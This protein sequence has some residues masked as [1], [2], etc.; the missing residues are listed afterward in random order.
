[1]PN[2]K[3]EAFE[4]GDAEFPIKIAFSIERSD[5]S[6]VLCT[7]NIELWNISPTHEKALM[8][9]GTKVYLCAGYDDNIPQIFEGTVVCCYSERDG[10]NRKT[11]IQCIDKSTTLSD[12]RI[13]ISQGETTA[14]ALIEYVR[15]NTYSTFSISDKAKL[16]LT[17]TKVSGYSFIGTA[18]DALKDICDLGGVQYRISN[19]IALIYLSGES[20][21]NKVHAIDAETG[22]IGFPKRIFESSLG[23]NDNDE[24]TGEYSLVGWEIEYLMNPSIGVGDKI[25]LTSKSAEL[26]GTFYVYQLQISGDNY[27]SDWTCTARIRE[28]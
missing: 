12:K 13:S 28:V 1:M 6:D 26:D 7:S 19:G 24:S 10:A 21:S 18:K 25:H 8:M 23:L 16:R 15:Q 4:I 5:G 11:T 9:S 14:Y 27:S 20:I 2:T 22:L 3:Y 17:G